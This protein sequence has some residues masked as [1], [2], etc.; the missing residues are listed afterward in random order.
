MIIGAVLRIAHPISNDLLG[1]NSGLETVLHTRN[2]ALYPAMVAE[3]TAAFAVLSDTINAIQTQLGNSSTNDE[4]DAASPPPSQPADSVVRHGR[5][6]LV[7]ILRRLQLAEQQKLSLTAALHLEQIRL[8]GVEVEPSAVGA[9][10]D[11]AKT[12]RLLEG[13]VQLL[14]SKVSSCVESINDVMEDLQCALVEE[15]ERYMCD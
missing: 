9:D 3:A 11:A 2:L 1:S 4:Q 12:R 5:D 6:D 15:T 14:R 7:A 13:G 10:G 8:Q